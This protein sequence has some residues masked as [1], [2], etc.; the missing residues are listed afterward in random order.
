VQSPIED[1]VGRSDRRGTA[2]H[3]SRRALAVAQ[4]EEEGVREMALAGRRPAGDL[5]EDEARRVRRQLELEGRGIAGKT[6]GHRMESQRRLAGLPVEAGI[7]ERHPVGCKLGGMIT[8]ALC[9]FGAA[10]LEQVGEVGG[11][12]DLDAEMQ[13]PV[14]EVRDGEALE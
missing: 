3:P 2:D 1:L 11:K 6:L 8:A 13:G 5:D 14:A 7:A 12:G 4:G 9:A 10:N